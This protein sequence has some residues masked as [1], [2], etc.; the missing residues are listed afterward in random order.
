LS[1]WPRC[2]DPHAMTQ[3]PFDELAGD[4]DQ[5]FERNGC[6]YSS[7]LS[8]L[9]ASL[10]AGL[11]LEIGVGTGRFAA[12]LAISVGL[13]PSVPMLRAAAGRG[14]PVVRGLAERLPFRDGA[15]DFALLVT[16]LC[17][18]KDPLAALR[19]AFR[20]T[21]PDGRLIVG[22]LDRASPLGK[23]YEVKAAESRFYGTARFLSV[24]EAEGLMLDAG[25]HVEGV[26]QAVFDKEVQAT[27]LEGHGQGLFAVISARK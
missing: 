1:A 25:W 5:W 24:Q 13:D 6:T 9:R 26:R 3:A 2:C 18:V 4:Y 11:G 16:V 8:A 10:P 17:F 14:V 12:P 15:F 19:E 20:V 21:R 7:E 22:L 27:F 23:V